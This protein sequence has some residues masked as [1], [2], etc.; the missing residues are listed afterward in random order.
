M[1]Y[2]VDFVKSGLRKTIKADSYYQYKGNIT[3]YANSGFAEPDFVERMF[4]IKPR[5]LQKTV[6]EILSDQD[7]II[8]K[9]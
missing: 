8:T 6:C 4:K 3:F 2:S 1:A 5:Q 7:V 9:I